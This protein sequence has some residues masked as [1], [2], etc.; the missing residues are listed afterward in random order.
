[1]NAI[2]WFL[3]SVNQIKITFLLKL[4]SL[5][6]FFYLNFFI[7]TSHRCSPANTFFYIVKFT[8]SLLIIFDIL[9]EIQK[10]LGNFYY[11]CLFGYCKNFMEIVFYVLCLWFV[12]IFMKNTIFCILLNCEKNT[13]LF[14]WKVPTLS[15]KSKLTMIK[16]IKS[17]HLEFA[18]E[19]QKKVSWFSF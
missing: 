18:Y 11:F 19:R 14:L 8:F 3:S 15:P 7:W 16:Q 6:I 12:I 17:I 13:T 2:F 5:M 10:P 9:F 1:M 4:F